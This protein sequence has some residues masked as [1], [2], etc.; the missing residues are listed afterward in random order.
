MAVGYRT[1]EGTD[2]GD[3]FYCSYTNEGELGYKVQDGTDIGNIFTKGSLGYEVGYKNQEGTDIG[4]LRGMVSTP[5]NVTQA[6]LVLR[7]KNRASSQI[8]QIMTLN[9]KTDQP[10]DKIKIQVRANIGTHFKDDD[11]YA[12]AVWGYQWT[13]TTY[14][15]SR[16]RPQAWL[17]LEGEFDMAGGTE[18]SQDFGIVFTP[19]DW[20]HFSCDVYCDVILTNALGESKGTSNIIYH[21]DDSWRAN[22]A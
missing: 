2:L 9:I 17:I 18:Y 19:D 6:E 8:S 5:P 12:G 1:K 7:E 13:W 22:N 21:S 16:R 11:T 20:Y 14:Q 10:A 15:G 3:V 4:Y